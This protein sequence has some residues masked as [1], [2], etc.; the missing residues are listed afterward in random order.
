ME[1]Y[2]I[3]HKVIDACLRADV[4]ILRLAVVF[5][6]DKKL[7]MKKLDEDVLTYKELT[8]ISDI[9]NCHYKS[10][11]LYDDNVKICAGEFNDMVRYAINRSG[12]CI[13]KFAADIGYSPAGLYAKL[14]RNKFT[15]S[16]L[17]GYGRVLGCK[18]ISEFYFPEIKAGIG[19][20]GYSGRNF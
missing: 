5:G 6:R 14:N 19:A 4:D 1:S 11:F 13:R 18:F 8:K 12:T 7:M 10:Y 15:Q 20:A 16:D 17:Y 3:K 2:F 9:L